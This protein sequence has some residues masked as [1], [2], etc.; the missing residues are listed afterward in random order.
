MLATRTTSPTSTTP[1][2]AK[3]QP[4]RLMFGAVY[5]SPLGLRCRL[6]LRDGERH[7]TRAALLLYD[8]EDG[9]PGQSYACRGFTLS[10]RNFHILR[11]VQAPPPLQAVGGGA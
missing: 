11:L 6:F 4:V 5:L 7:N 9:T 3:P 2:D 8:R 1:P 10:A